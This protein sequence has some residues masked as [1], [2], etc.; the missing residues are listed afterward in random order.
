M[1]T[2][3]ISKREWAM[4][5]GIA[6]IV[7]ILCQIPYVLGY[8]LAPKGIE[9]TGLMINVEDGSYLSA[10]G[11][12]MKGA[13]LY[14]LPFTTEEHAPV[15]IEGFY[16]WLGHLARLF[17]LSAVTM[18]HLARGIADLILCV[19]LFGFIAQFLDSTRQRIVAYLLAIFGAGYDLWRLPFDTPDVFEAVPIELRIPEAHLFYSALTYP[20]FAISVALLLMTFYFILQLF[21]SAN[22]RVRPWCY[23]IGAGLGNLLLGF[24]YPFLIYL[25]VAVTGIYYMFLTWRERRILLRQTVLLFVAFA[26]PAPLFLYYQLVLMTQPIFRNWNQQATTVS[27]H[28]IHFVLA[29]LLYLLFAIPTLKLFNRFSETQKRWLSFLWVWVGAVAILLYTPISQQRRFVEG[30]QV[31]LAILAVLGLEQIVY[32]WLDEHVF[33]KLS[34]R[35]HYTIAGLRRLVVVVIIL[36]AS[37][38]SAYVWISSVVLLGFGQPYPLFRPTTEL[39]AMDWLRANTLPTDNIFSSY[40]SGSFIPAR[41]GNTVFVGQ[42]YETLR[43]EEKRKASE[44]FWD[45]KTDDAWRYDLLRS[46]RIGYVFWGRGE[47]DLGDFD[48][49]HTN[50]LEQVFSN[51]TTRIYRVRIQ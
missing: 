27:P 36:V 11:Q 1:Q 45:N 7:V 41:S 30:V 6:L 12:G 33:V 4:A 3:S 5:V 25:I 44:D 13:W 22:Q 20:H 35:P 38:S 14:H 40:W 46:Y 43:F 2:N 8:V 26:I 9:F 37:I 28:P 15:L 34:Q 48:P 23:A 31:P 47:R 32:P 51:A 42:R 18:W 49:E 19:A 29:Y 10:I 21:N 24:V 39:Q 50:Y 17:N 16:L